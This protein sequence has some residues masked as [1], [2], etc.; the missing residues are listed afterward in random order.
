MIHMAYGDLSG[1]E[2]ATL[3]AGCYL[4]LQDQWMNAIAAWCRA[5]ADAGVKEF[6]AT[7]FYSTRG[8]FDDDK[9]RR[10]DAGRGKKIPGGA[11]HDRF[12]ARFTSIPVASGLIGFAHSL[13]GPAFN[14]IL[15]PVMAQERRSYTAAHARTFAI[16]K[17]LS[18]ASRFL[19]GT[20]YRDPD[21]IQAIFEEENGAGKF[22][23]FFAESKRRDERWT[24]WFKSFTT[25]PKAFAPVQMGDLLAH[26]TWRRTKQ[27]W[28]SGEPERLRKSFDN[29]LGDGRI[30]LDAMDRTYCI[31]EAERVRAILA[32]FPD[33]LMP[34]EMSIDDEFPLV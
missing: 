27:V 6:H 11:L 22:L 13:D 31:K 17:S 24:Y 2:S 19:G 23:N 20:Q 34:A 14:A 5:L 15:A 25:A 32:R 8:E 1:D 26:E 21:R 7:D 9:W 18:A 16:F 12:A 29:M 10:F 4:G 33:G 30:Q 28:Y 3:T